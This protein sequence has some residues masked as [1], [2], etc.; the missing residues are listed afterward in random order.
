[1]EKIKALWM[2]VYTENLEKF[3]ENVGEPSGAFL[4]DHLLLFMAIIYILCGMFV[5]N[6]PNSEIIVRIGQ[7]DIVWNAIMIAVLMAGGVCM[8]IHWLFLLNKICW[9]RD[10]KRVTVKRC[11]FLLKILFIVVIPFIYAKKV[12]AF[13]LRETRQKEI[14]IYIPEIFL[15][16][17]L[18]III[19]FIV[20]IP[21]IEKI[22]I[23]LTGLIDISA[24]KEF[25][26]LCMVIAFIATFFQICKWIIHI[27]IKWLVWDLKRIKLKKN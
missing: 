10:K 18:S 20:E 19:F 4:R 15:A 21:F 7:G 24:S 13:V 6:Y 17:L 25:T 8:L 26:M 11:W 3:I 22:I 2:K 1:M 23:W 16:L 14:V 5:L 9:K 12:I 27:S